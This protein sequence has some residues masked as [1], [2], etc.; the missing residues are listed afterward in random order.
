MLLLQF[1][2]L[3]WD[4][5]IPITTIGTLGSF[6]IL[7]FSGC[8]YE[9]KLT[10]NKPILFAP[11]QFEDCFKQ[12]MNICF[13]KRNRIEKV[14]T[15]AKEY[16][17]T[18]K[19]SVKDLD[20]LVIVIDNIDRCPS[21]MAYQLL[22]DIKTFFCDEKYNIVFV[23]PIDEKAL[24]NHIFRKWNQDDDACI[25]IEKEEFLRKI[26]NV[27]LR[28]KTHQETEL[29]FFANELNNKYQLGYSAD[30]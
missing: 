2:S 8:F 14:L 22:A 7:L 30:T 20:K 28:I 9:L 13:K 24:K 11:E 4:I 19:C 18:G 10:I 29:Q 25:N 23:V 17:T 26:F 16:V 6:L 3:N 5:K 12:M 1:S 21:D 15:N 27:V